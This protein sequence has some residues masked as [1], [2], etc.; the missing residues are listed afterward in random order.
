MV[1]WRS[2]KA[3]EPIVDAACGSTKHASGRIGHGRSERHY[4]TAPIVG[5]SADAVGTCFVTCNGKTEITESV[6]IALD[7]VFDVEFDGVVRF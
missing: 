3:A 6:Q 2:G 7:P 4:W 5:R 1:T